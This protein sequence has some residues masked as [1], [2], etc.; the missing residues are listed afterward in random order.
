VSTIA[1]AITYVIAL[2]RPDLSR[3]LAQQNDRLRQVAQIYPPERAG[4]RYQRTYTLRDAWKPIGP[5]RSGEGW[6]AGVENATTYAEYVMGD[7]QGEYFEGRWRTA[8]AIAEAEEE[9]V[10]LAIESELYRLA[11]V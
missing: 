11:G 8:S 6:I 2:Q 1:E 7:D 5:I 10:A 9:T 3:V 4:Q